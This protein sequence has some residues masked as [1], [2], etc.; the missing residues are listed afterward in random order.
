MPSFFHGF[1]PSWK[2]FIKCGHPKKDMV[3]NFLTT[4][5]LAMSFGLNPLLGLLEMEMDDCWGYEGIRG[6][7]FSSW[8]EYVRKKKYRHI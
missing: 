4:P 1:Y 5:L 2:P 7:A 3:T 8:V 6:R